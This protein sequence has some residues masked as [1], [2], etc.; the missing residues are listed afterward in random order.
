MKKILLHP[1]IDWI[2]IFVCFDTRIKDAPKRHSWEDPENG[3]EE[4]EDDELSE[5]QKGW[6]TFVSSYYW[7]RN[8]VLLWKVMQIQEVV[9]GCGG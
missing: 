9:V 2:H 8:W 4:E 1:K 7:I 3:G 6:L 5:P